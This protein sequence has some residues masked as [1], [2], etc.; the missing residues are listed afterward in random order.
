MNK[1]TLTLGVALVALVL[2]IGAYSYPVQDNLVGGPSRFPNS[3]IVAKSFT[4]TNSSAT[5]TS[6]AGCLQ[7]TATSSATSI[8]LSFGTSATTTFL[9]TA[10]GVVAWHYGTCP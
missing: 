1:D 9:G 2:A 7:T 3:D 5:S 6:A 10:G 4:A 8:K